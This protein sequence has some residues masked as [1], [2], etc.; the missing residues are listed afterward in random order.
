MAVRR[1]PLPRS[2]RDWLLIAQTA[3]VTIG[4]AYSLQF[5][6]QQ[7]VPSGL[8]AVM[9]ATVPLFTMLFAHLH[10]PTE[11]LTWFKLSGV[12]LGI[13]GVT[14][15]FS[16]QLQADSVLA[17]WGCAGFLVAAA[18]MAFAQVAV[19]QRGG[20]IDPVILAAFQMGIGGA[21]L[22]V[23]GIVAAER[24]SDLAW[25]TSAIASLAYLSLFGSALAFFLFYW[26]LKHMKVTTVMSMALVHPVIAVIAGWLMLGE[27]LSWRA[28]VGGVGVLAGLGL[29][30]E[31]EV[32]GSRDARV[33]R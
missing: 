26:L 5:W 6:G 4:L 27:T 10:L 2:A 7:Y 25:T 11:R 9:F 14:L 18:S 16:D 3:L 32:L 29:M 12:L 17:V 1:V 20:H 22:F 15:I 33:L 30:L 8:T 21:A 13:L 24:L 23:L 28:F 31:G 19:K